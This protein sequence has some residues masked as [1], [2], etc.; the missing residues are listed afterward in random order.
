MRAKLVGLFLFVF[1][2][3]LSIANAPD[4]DIRSESRN[5]VISRIPRARVA[6]NVIATVGYS[7]RRHIL[8]IEFLNGAVYRYLNVPSSVYRDLMQANSKAR[9][10]VTNIKGSYPSLRVRRHVKDHTE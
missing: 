3:Q 1:T 6:S 10:Y 8:E 2:Q 5:P 7:K 4:E 9:Y